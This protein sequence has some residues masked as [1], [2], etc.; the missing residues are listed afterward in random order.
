MI[1]DDDVYVTGITRGGESVPVLR[2]GRWEI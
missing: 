1:G 2:G